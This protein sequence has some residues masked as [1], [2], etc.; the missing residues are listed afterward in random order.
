[1]TRGTVIPTYSFCLKT[2]KEPP[3]VLQDK[4]LATP[5]Q[6]FEED[7]VRAQAGAH[8]V[9]LRAIQVAQLV[10]VVQVVGQDLWV[11]PCQMPRRLLGRPSIN[12]YVLQAHGADCELSRR[13]YLQR[14]PPPHNRLTGGMYI[15][16]LRLGRCCRPSPC[17]IR[18][19]RLRSASESAADP[20]RVSP[21]VPAAGQGIV[22]LAVAGQ[23]LAGLAFES[24]ATGLRRRRI[25]RSVSL[26]RF[27]SFR[28][29]FAS[30]TASP[31]SLFSPH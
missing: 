19:P 1:M 16:S 25:G 9:V 8:H 12:V 5:R 7:H 2:R 15:Q 23:G 6:V 27:A 13:A 11:H 28:S 24:N 22:G 10:Q 29:P 26:R 30:S 4:G 20:R 17:N 14:H 21:P 3:Q 31:L 18:H